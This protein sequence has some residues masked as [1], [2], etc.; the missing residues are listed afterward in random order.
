MRANLERSTKTDFSPKSQQT[1]ESNRQVSSAIQ[2]VDNRRETLVQKG[3]KQMADQRLQ[4]NSPTFFSDGVPVLT[5]SVNRL[6]DTLNSQ[7]QY[8]VFQKKENNTGLPDRLKSGIENLSGVSMDDVKV[9]RNSDK[10]AQLQAHAYAQDTD[11]HLA[12]GQEKHLPHEAWHVVQQKQGR[13]KPTLQMKGAVNIND[14][15]GLENEADVMGAKALQIN[16]EIKEVEASFPH[17]RN[18][19]NESNVI[20]GAF[21]IKGVALTGEVLDKWLEDYIYGRPELEAVVRG[22]ATDDNYTEDYDDDIKALKEANN[23]AKE[24][25]ASSNSEVGESIG[26]N[27]PPNTVAW[28]THPVWAAWYFNGLEYQDNKT[29]GWHSNR[30]GLLPGNATEDGAPTRYVEFR[31]PGAVGKKEVD[32]MERCIFDLLSGR[33]YPNAHYDGG[34]VEIT[35][36]PNGVK[37]RLMNIALDCTGI[38]E[39]AKAMTQE[40][41]LE[42]GEDFE[43]IQWIINHY[44][45]LSDRI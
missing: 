15:A 25:I 40:E 41:K 12:P 14:D 42:A 23:V 45:P 39:R 3:I 10:P 18:V 11:I 27:A 43:K 38:K 30:A 22:W 16:K 19:S 35:G 1:H 24:T 8:P 36:I 5:E 37:R 13:V 32:K 20:Q 2:F 34:Y 28:D 33:C 31:R 26:T 29:G 9:H 17:S 7:N 4:N 44:Q 21:I 6:K